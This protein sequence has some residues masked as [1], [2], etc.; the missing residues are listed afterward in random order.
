MDGMPCLFQEDVSNLSFGYVFQK[1]RNM[2]T[3]L[4]ASILHMMVGSSE[5]RQVFEGTFQGHFSIQK[6]ENFPK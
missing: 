1:N 2:H 5:C 6:Q 3:S 4:K